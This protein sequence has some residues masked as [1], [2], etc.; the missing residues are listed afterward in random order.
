MTLNVNNQVAFCGKSNE[1]HKALKK[2][3]QAKVVS[4]ETMD[5]LGIEIPQ[6]IQRASVED[7]NANFR[8]KIAKILGKVQ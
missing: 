7:L 2:L 3:E 8:E 1:I 4:N 5:K 6:Q